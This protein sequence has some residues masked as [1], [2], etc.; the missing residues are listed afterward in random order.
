MQ[1]V[2]PTAVISAFHA[3]LTLV[4][5]KDRSALEH[6]DINCEFKMQI[7]FR[8]GW[9]QR[10]GQGIPRGPHRLELQCPDQDQMEHEGGCALQGQGKDSL[11]RSNFY[12]VPKTF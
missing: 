2:K 12:C 4:F 3:N 6:L 7:L 8:E 5:V 10:Q 11:S 9:Q 1:P